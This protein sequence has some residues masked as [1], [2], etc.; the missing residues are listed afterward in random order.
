MSRIRQIQMVVAT[1]GSLY[2]RHDAVVHLGGNR[3]LSGRIITRIYLNDMNFYKFFCSFRENWPKKVNT[4][5][6]MS[7]TYLLEQKRICKLPSARAPYQCCTPREGC[8][9][10]SSEPLAIFHHIGTSVR[11]ATRIKFV[12]LTF[13]EIT[14]K[15]FKLFLKLNVRLHGVFGINLLLFFYS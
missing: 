14:K 4:Y 7:L 11:G 9:S 5:S 12:V 10:L 2:Y 6:D 8:S 1:T 13:H 15:L 3:L